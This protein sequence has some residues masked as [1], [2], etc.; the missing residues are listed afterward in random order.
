MKNKQ[1]IKERI[2]LIDEMIASAEHK[3]SNAFFVKQYNAIKADIVRLN[4]LRKELA[5]KL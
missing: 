3:L 5:K 2:E 4:N 1:K